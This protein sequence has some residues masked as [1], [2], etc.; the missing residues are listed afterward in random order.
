MTKDAEEFSHFDGHVACREY[1]SPRDDESSKSQGWIRGSTKIGPV[2]EKWQQATIK[3]NT[4][5]RSELN[6][7][8]KMDLHSW[9]RISTWTQQIRERT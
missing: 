3:Q 1:T 6:H 8:Q 2:M 5:L 7:H 4:E 9:I